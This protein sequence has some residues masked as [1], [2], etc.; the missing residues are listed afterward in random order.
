M[1]HVLRLQPG[2][3]LRPTLERWA[4]DRKVEAASIVSAVG[5][6]S[7]AHL[8]YAGHDHGT[9]TT[10]DLEICSL[11]GTLSIHGSHLHIS[12]ADPAG[13]LS[14]GHVLQGCIVRTTLEIVILEI[15]GVRMARAQDEATGYKELD[16]GRVPD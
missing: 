13:M 1:V 14:G 6:L 5:S 11:S 9:R 7:E 8:R 15:G 2:E 10:T 16:P 4:E 3:D 12:V